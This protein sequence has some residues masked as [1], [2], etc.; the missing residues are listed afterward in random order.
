[1]RYPYL[2]LKAGEIAFHL[3]TGK[4]INLRE[5]FSGIFLG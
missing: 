5:Y 3:F 1:M 2:E 4:R